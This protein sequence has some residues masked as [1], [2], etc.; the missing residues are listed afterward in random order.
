MEAVKDH[1]D[2]FAT[3]KT[4]QVSHVGRFLSL[5]IFPIM[6][7]VYTYFLFFD[8]NAGIITSNMG[9]ATI[10]PEFQFTCAKD[11][12]PYGCEVAAVGT[13]S[14]AIF[15][16]DGNK[17]LHNG[18]MKP[19]ERGNFV[20]CP[21]YTDGLD[22]SLRAS[23]NF[24][25][26]GSQHNT[27]I[28]ASCR[29]PNRY[30]HLGIFVGA[31][32][33]LVYIVDLLTM[34][35][36]VTFNLRSKAE[37]QGISKCSSLC[38]S[39]ENNM[40]GAGGATLIACDGKLIA[41]NPSFEKNAQTTAVLVHQFDKDFQPTTGFIDPKSVAAFI[42]GMYGD[43][44]GASAKSRLHRVTL[45]NPV[46]TEIEF[47]KYDGTGNAAKIFT[48]IQASML[49]YDPRKDQCV[50]Q[51]ITTP[52]LYSDTHP[53][54]GNGIPATDP[55]DVACKA[56]TTSTACAAASCTWRTK[57]ESYN[58]GYFGD[59]E[60]KVY[61]I[62]NLKDAASGTAVAKT[63]DIDIFK[64]SS[65][66]HVGIGKAYG[67][68]TA[69]GNNEEEDHKAD[70]VMIGTGSGTVLAY[71][72][73]FNKEIWKATLSGGQI[74]V[75][76]DDKF[77]NTKS[78]IGTNYPGTLYTLDRKN[79]RI[80]QATNMDGSIT[81]GFIVSDEAA[82]CQA[83]ISTE[84]GVVMKM[85][86]D[87][88]Q[89]IDPATGKN[90]VT[91]AGPWQ[92]LAKRIGYIRKSEDLQLNGSQIPKEVTI[93]GETHFTFPPA[94]E[95]LNVFTM[96]GSRT[97]DVN[98]GTLNASF[99]AY[100]AVAVAGF[101]QYPCQ[102]KQADTYCKRIN[103]AP[104]AMD[105]HVSPQYSTLQVVSIYLSF[106]FGVIYFLLL[107]CAK[108][109]VRGL[110]LK[111]VWSANPFSNPTKPPQTELT[112][113]RRKSEFRN[114]LT[115]TEKTESPRR[116]SALIKKIRGSQKKVLENNDRSEV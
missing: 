27:P 71:N 28:A 66:A 96:V 18:T 42:G 57:V 6:V 51:Y 1:V 92:H 46:A 25:P 115:E 37:F 116:P 72:A 90:V 84:E 12:A 19:G 99:L 24:N 53:L 30:K 9:V 62:D 13:K 106:V 78:F 94:G 45:N 56:K 21:G 111:T 74:M 58:F 70:H 104:L 89:A 101:K 77:A 91:G 110:N 14:K 22:I 43:A 44:I 52:P 15:A 97:R 109:I 85:T 100:D 2:F 3:K 23:Q 8:V 75:I 86:S 112:T 64:D 73:D 95:G 98:A 39:T 47:K 20:L 5:I 59:N 50:K 113:G 34:Q 7:G 26:Q 87:I 16:K 65:G 29:A 76:A 60:G 107:V 82:Q 68:I 83:Y 38:L 35:R 4:T 108:G 10:C 105:V 41:I 80:S 88:T 32:N 63:L 69:F 31:T 81:T 93:S 40:G 36:K 49:R 11:T 67:A 114:P 54:A 55:S 79:G 33:G 102:T 61:F 48:D 17:K 103:L